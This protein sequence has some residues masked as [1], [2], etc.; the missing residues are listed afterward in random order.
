[1][2]FRLLMLLL[3]LTLGSGACFATPWTYE[4]TPNCNT[5]YHQFLSLH[6]DEGRAAI[7]REIRSNPYNLMATF[8]SDY[9]DFIVLMLNC[10]KEDFEQRKGHLDTRITLLEN[11]DH[12]SPWYRFC[13]AGIY[14][15]WTVIYMRFG[16]HLKAANT[17]R[18]SY[19]LLKDNRQNYPDFAYN[20]IF[21][22]IEEAVVGSL[23]GNYKWLASIMGI[24]GSIKGGIEKLKHFVDTHN[25]NEPFHLETELYYE[26]T[27]FYFE[28]KHKEVWEAINGP[29]FATDNNLL[30]AY[31]KCY[32][33]LDYSKSDDVVKMI[34][35]V[36]AYRDFEHYP[37]FNFQ[38]GVALLT[39]LDSNC[40]TYFTTF[41]RNNKGEMHVKE[42]WH[43]MAFYWYIKGQQDKAN[44]CRQQ[45]PKAGSTE[46][47]ADKNADKFA[48][49][50]Q[51]PDRKLLE[52]RMLLD[53]GYYT[54]AYQ[55][56]TGMN[57][58]TLTSNADRAEY[59]YRLGRVYEESA[60]VS[61]AIEYFNRSIRASDGQR[62][63]FAARSALHKGRV[64]E[65]AGDKAHARE[66]Y[67]EALNMP[68]HDFQNSIDQQ[69][70][71]GIN[72]L[73]DKL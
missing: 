9:E 21:T 35:K 16:E 11:S 65:L 27:R 56:L 69:A 17:F 20:L 12:N 34:H 33:A 22:G 6:F 53:G 73:D 57:Y 72:R 49:G 59:F 67:E 50:T 55:V 32:L 66:A 64:Y 51:W 40:I 62:D 1:M 24:K 23:P 71:A 18:K 15:H 38:M 28:A 52:A 60:D 30:N 61:H 2:R 31:F 46:L 36:S 14:L 10:D 7:F 48:A 43:K 5:A 54:R 19:A 63:Q 8:V 41:L 58:N 45:I 29:Q 37:F 26:Y 39:N 42:A 68:A 3:C 13:K 25:D 44:Y 47:D 70:K 4:Y